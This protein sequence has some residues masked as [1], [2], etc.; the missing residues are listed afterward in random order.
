[1]ASA[2]KFKE[3]INKLGSKIKRVFTAKDKD[4]TPVF[5]DSVAFYIVLAFALEFL[6]EVLCRRS[7][8]SALRFLVF[9]P[10]AFFV[11]T[12]LIFFLLSLSMLAPFRVG[13]LTFLTLLCTGFAV[14]DC[15]MMGYRVTPLN[16]NDLLLFPSIVRIFSVYFNVWQIIGICLLLAAAVALVVFIFIKSPKYKVKWVKA[17]CMILIAAVL[18]PALI[19]L[20]V[21][22][23]LLSR[24]FPNLSDAYDDYGF[25]YCFILSA[26]DRGVE[27]PGDYSEEK[28]NS[29]LSEIGKIKEN[30]ADERPNVIFVQLESF[31]NVNEFN[32]LSFS[33]N[34]I[35]HYEQ[36]KNKYPHGKLL[37]PSI[38]AG[39]VNTEF[40]ILSGM[41]LSYFGAGEYPYKT[42][43][44]KYT[45]ETMAYNLRELG[46]K[47]HA[48]HN[49]EG[50]FYGRNEVYSKL[51]FESFTPMEY[52]EKLEYN[53]SG[54]WIRDT[55]LTDEILSSLRSTSG[56]DFV[57][58]IS[59]QAHGKYP[60]S[61]LSEDYDPK[62]EVSIVDEAKESS[63]AP[64]EAID[65]YINQ[66]DEVDDFVY[67]LTNAVLSL[68][69]KTVL[70]FYGDHLPSLSIMNSD[71]DG[72]DIFETEY[73]IVRN[74]QDDSDV[75]FG[76]LHAYQLSSR[77]MSLIGFNHG[78]LTK[79]HQNFS[80]N[81]DY[82][83][84]LNELEYDM[85]GDR[86]KRFVYGGDF[87]HYPIVSEMRM[88]T[89]E[90]T[91][92]GCELIDNVLHVYGTHFTT[93]SMIR[94][95]DQLMHET[96]FVS[97][98]ELTVPFDGKKEVDNVFV[99]QVGSDKIVLSVSD[100][101]E[102]NA[103][104]KD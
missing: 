48:I 88:G 37:V 76:D 65:Y 70:V 93:F 90:I 81:D 8:V 12:L 49:Y 1:M 74:Y 11:C 103:Q 98:T 34:P 31:F 77:V 69:E 2:T 57:F 7:F 32:N 25:P 87:E 26:V 85:L 24:K 59:V 4:G 45:C 80:E 27:R 20:G 51:G 38:G 56:S 67:E 89:N 14:A 21:S 97:S 54:N 16:V 40:E 35:E 47:T 19:A 83:D 30:N 46:Y 62:I 18:I 66:I 99:A 33:D 43:L 22:T 10:Y 44:K 6:T 42:V 39:T 73:M 63:L 95:D 92:S 29:I 3:R 75:D 84:W 82:L 50:S 36:L 72:S 64:L 5:L 23:T 71:L 55:V 79:L 68:D 53:A 61:S 96:E 91:I 58:A 101:W 78:I 9:S 86:G 60:P 15:I 102:Y 13:L 17:V 94:L 104:N 52:M 28:I 41:N 100:L